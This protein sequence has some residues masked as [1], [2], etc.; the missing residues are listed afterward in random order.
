MLIIKRAIY[1]A[2]SCVLL[3]VLSA[4][5]NYTNNN[6]SDSTNT[7]TRHT[8]IRINR[9]STANN[10]RHTR[11]VP[12]RYIRNSKPQTRPTRKVAP[13]L[14]INQSSEPI[15]I[16]APPVSHEQAQSPVTMSAQQAPVRSNINSTNNINPTPLP[17]IPKPSPIAQNTVPAAT[18]DIPIPDKNMSRFARIFVTRQG[19]ADAAGQEGPQGGADAG[20]GQKDRKDDRFLTGIGIT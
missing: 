18:N 12:A 1:V 19:S 5:G 17:Q 20:L 3:F 14:R 7:P 11:P 15:P 4:C 8:P 16:P 2:V 13:N 10:T 9:S 6:P